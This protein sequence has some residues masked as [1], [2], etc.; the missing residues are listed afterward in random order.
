[1]LGDRVQRGGRR[2]RLRKRGE[3]GLRRGAL[4]VEGGLWEKRVSAG[5]GLCGGGGREG[6]GS[7]LG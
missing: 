2:G 3:G 4:R 5:D 6:V 7:W 1:M